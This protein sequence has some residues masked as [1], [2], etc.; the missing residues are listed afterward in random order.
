MLSYGQHYTPRGH[1]SPMRGS[2]RS[3]LGLSEIKIKH[4]EGVGAGQRCRDGT[5]IH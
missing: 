2:L 1:I 4:A 3:G 5:V